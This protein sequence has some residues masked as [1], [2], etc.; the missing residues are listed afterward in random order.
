MTTQ[1][2]NIKSNR[3]NENM[4]DLMNLNEDMTGENYILANVIATDKLEAKLEQG[5][6]AT[7]RRNPSDTTANTEAVGCHQSL[8]NIFDPEENAK[9]SNGVEH[10]Q[11]NN[12]QND[13]LKDDM[14]QVLKNIL[15]DFPDTHT[16]NKE[17]GNIS[18]EDNK[19]NKKDV[20]NISGE[21]NKD[22]KKD[23]LNISGED[24]KD[25]KKDVLNNS[26]EDSK[27]IDTNID[28][29][30]LEN[31]SKFYWMAFIIIML[32]IVMWWIKKHL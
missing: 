1:S 9:L 18:D 23:V 14:D 5:T 16:D 7:H 15:R 4:D 20:L 27:L 24:N 13:K 11:N 3:K 22:N 28:H 19:D 25:N 12:Q 6:T 29:K 17:D 31:E 26:G 10:E 30:K 32:G 8:V 21:D 2:P